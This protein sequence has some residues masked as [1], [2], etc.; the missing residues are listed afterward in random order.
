MISIGRLFSSENW[1]GTKNYLNTQRYYEMA[2]TFFLFGL[3]GA[4]FGL[5]IHSTGTRL[6]LLTI[7]AVLGCL[8]ASKSLV[9]LI[10]FCRYSSPKKDLMEDIDQHA[11]QLSRLYD[12]VFTGRERNFFVC[13]L[14]VKGNTVCGY[15]TEK[16]FDEQAFEKHILALLRADSLTNVSIKIFDDLPKYLTRLDQMQELSC[17]EKNTNAIL[18]TLKSV[19]L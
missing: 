15:T 5:G 2:R 10:M 7:V 1:K 4:L 9:S 3:S 12:L 11:G 13:H 14:A 8:P 17:D 16:G 6:N 19:S 18:D